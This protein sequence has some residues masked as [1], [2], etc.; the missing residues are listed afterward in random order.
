MFARIRK[1]SFKCSVV[2]IKNPIRKYALP[3]TKS[4]QSDKTIYPPIL[5]LCKKEQ[6]R[7]EKEEWHNKIK[8]LESVEEKLFG[9]NMPRYY[10]WRCLDLNDKHIAYNSLGMA[11][12]ITKT[13]IASDHKL[14]DFYDK[15]ITS[16]Q[17]DT[18]V[19]SIKTPIEDAIIF[20]YCNRLRTEES[21]EKISELRANAVVH[22]IN[23]ILLSA[24]ASFFPHLMEVQVD[25]EPRLEAFWFVGKAPRGS[26]S[27][28]IA[29]VEPKP[30]KKYQLKDMPVQYVGSPILQLRNKFPLKE[31]ISLNELY[32]LEFNVPKFNLNP[33][34]LGH[35]FLYK[36]AT[37]IPGF[38]PGDPDEFGSLSYH[39]TDNLLHRP[40][41][42]D[43]TL[44]A[45]TVQAIIAS[46]GWLLSQAC[47]QGFSTLNE[48]T[49]PLVS[50]TVITDG[51]SW[52]FCTYQLNTTL[53]RS[54]FMDENPMCNTCWITK[55]EILFDTVENEKIH[56]FNE[57]ALKTL[58]KFYINT[59][60]ERTGVNL[61]PYLGESVKHIADIPDNERRI[62]LEKHFKHLM[63]NRPR[64][65]RVP[66]IPDWQK[67]YM[68]KHNTRPLEKRRDPWQFGFKPSQRR[69]DDHTPVYIPRCLRLHPNKR[70]I[71]RWAKTYY[72]D[73]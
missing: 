45:V 1:S 21:V 58:I 19:Q 15:L 5:D 46:Y 36:H 64:H 40:K 39:Y 11:Q 65:L 16:E 22:Q 57:D 68:I 34:V 48:I 52:S 55:P 7:R 38:W 69:L 12:Y 43:D 2:V 14:P 53:L 37:S 70:K 4:D 31:V 47:Y 35:T 24:L 71:G 54:P 49:Y 13:H 8:K 28:A 50:Q 60:Q 56:G 66:E 33:K 67:I 25:F 72:P 44:D 32:T 3:V 59:P 63:T 6:L 73:A 18:L 10:G 26:A 17:L 61:K 9:I 30:F 29:E 51:Q 41:T 27:D 23:R 20:E 42:M 62:W